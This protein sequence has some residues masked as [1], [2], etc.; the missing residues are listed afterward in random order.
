MKDGTAVRHTL[1][2][3]RG[4]IVQ[5][6]MFSP[7]K[8]RIHLHLGH[9]S[10]RERPRCIEKEVQLSHVPSDLYRDFRKNIPRHRIFSTKVCIANMHPAITRKTMQRHRVLAAKGCIANRKPS[11]QAKFCSDTGFSPQKCVSRTEKRHYRQNSAA[12]QIFRLKRVCRER[13]HC[14]F[15]SKAC[16]ANRVGSKECVAWKQCAACDTGGLQAGFRRAP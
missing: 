4:T 16:I 10:A 9:F 3:L 14:H 7:S 1:D 11:L 15:G 6:M 2:V 12:T 8:S 13:L 5:G